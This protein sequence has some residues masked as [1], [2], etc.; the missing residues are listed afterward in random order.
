MVTNGQYAEI[1]E[2]LL[3][4]KDQHICRLSATLHLEILLPFELLEKGKRI[5]II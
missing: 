1:N 2:L 4:F 3:S 5:H